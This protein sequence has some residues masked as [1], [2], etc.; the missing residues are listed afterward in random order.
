M[1]AHE[2]GLKAYLATVE[3]L[4]RHANGNC[5]AIDR[6]AVTRMIGRLGSRDPDIKKPVKEVST[7]TSTS[8]STNGF[9]YLGR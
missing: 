9:Q 2:R 7:V 6:Q 1:L 3:L 5:R 8:R 4:N